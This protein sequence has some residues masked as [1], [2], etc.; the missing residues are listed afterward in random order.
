VELVVEQGPEQGRVVPLPAGRGT[1]GSDPR[2]AHVVLRDP[3]VAAGPLAGEVQP[4]GQV[5]VWPVGG[6][7]WVDARP[8]TGAVQLRPGARVRLGATTLLLQADTTTRTP[9][10]ASRNRRRRSGLVAGVA[11]M[12]LAGGALLA[13]LFT[14]VD[15]PGAVTSM[16]A[17]VLP[18]PLLV[19]LVLAVDRYEPEPKRVLGLTFLYGATAAVL[20]AG[21]LNVAGFAFA[22][23]GGGGG[24]GGGRARGGGAAGGGRGREARGGGAGGGAGEFLTV[25]VVAP[26]VEETLKSLAVL[27]VFWRLRDQFNGVVDAIVYSGMVGLGFAVTENAFYYAGALVEGAD[28]FTAVIV[29]RGVFSPFAHPLF[30]SM[31]GIGLAVAGETARFRALPPILGL[32]AA[33]FLHGLWNAATFLG[34]GFF[35]VYL[36]VFVP[37]FI[38]VVVA[39]VLASA[40]EARL[41]RAY[42]APDVHSGLLTADEVEKLAS[43]RLR[44]QA[45]REATR[46]GGESGKQARRAFH[47][48]ATRLAFLRHRRHKRALHAPSAEEEARWVAEVRRRKAV[49]KGG[50]PA[51]G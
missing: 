42:L 23:G 24:G 4:G 41:I 35:L 27:V 13:G 15:A 7:V 38:A 49:A 51:T 43:S 26:V 8:A 28:V 20:F 33:V 5:T 36:F 39:A 18:A 9:P 45:E 25:S 29:I 21:V 50:L 40:R 44:R 34:P 19:A 30:T 10:A 17:A 1:I 6:P 32:G 16:L 48:A 22:G 47:H 2:Q 12:T 31:F 14:T 11:G 46:L 3:G 37:L